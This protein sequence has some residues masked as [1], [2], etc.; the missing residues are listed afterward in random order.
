M[1]SID[2]DHDQHLK[3]I[4]CFQRTGEL[5]VPSLITISSGIS[6]GFLMLSPASG[7]VKIKV[8]LT[9]YL[10]RSSMVFLPGN[11]EGYDR[12]RPFLKSS[13]YYSY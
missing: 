10:N 3:Y 7:L 8:P 4:C 9:R 12:L 5:G 2:L 13:F 1:R 11:S 6:I